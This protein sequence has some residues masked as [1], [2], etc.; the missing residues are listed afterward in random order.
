MTKQE[1][2]ENAFLKA[3]GNGS[4]EAR[5]NN[6]LKIKARMVAIDSKYDS[7]IIHNIENLDEKDVRDVIRSLRLKF[8]FV[9]ASNK[10]YYLLEN[11]DEM[12]E[13]YHS[14]TGRINTMQDVA[15]ALEATI[16]A[17]GIVI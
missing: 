2:I 12:V 16:L 17:S 7:E 8:H 1:L 10:G 11:S 6:R 4:K 9:A 3:L 5:T 15:N 13:Y 14:F